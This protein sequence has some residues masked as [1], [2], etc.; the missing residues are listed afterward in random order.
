MT[1]EFP[2][3]PPPR[4]R[5]R[6]SEPRETNVLMVAL[7]AFVFGVFLHGCVALSILDGGSSAGSAEGPRPTVQPAATQTAADESRP[8]PLPDRTS[9]AEI[10][11]TEYRS[12]AERDFY[13]ANCIPTPTPVPPTP[14]PGPNPTA[15]T[16]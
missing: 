12:I 1:A 2:T 3:P 15:T 7:I 4:P 14:T 13:R 11:G 5:R 16:G 6:D 10:Q 8:T 9:C